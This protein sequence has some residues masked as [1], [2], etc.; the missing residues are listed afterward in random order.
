VAT[1]N[2]GKTQVLPRSEHFIIK[3]NQ[4]MLCK[5]KFAVCSEIDIN[6][7]HVNTVW[8]MCTIFSRVRKIAKSD[9]W[10]R[11]VC[12]SAWNNWAPTGRIFMKCDTFRSYV[13]KIQVSLNLTR[14][15]GTLREY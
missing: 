11:H 7:A 3:T 10:L 2:L 12:P 14:I 4:C 15:T 1:W 9:Y 8:V 6:T 13:E 5:A